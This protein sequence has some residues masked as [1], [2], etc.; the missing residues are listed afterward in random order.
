MK[1]LSTVILLLGT[2][3]CKAQT[4]LQ[5]F[6]L[7]NGGNIKTNGNYTSISVV[8]E[9][10]VSEYSN[11]NYSGT[12]GYLDNTD[13]DPLSI[14]KIVLENMIVD[15]YPNPTKGDTWVKLSLPNTNKVILRVFNNIGISVF[16]EHYSNSKSHMLK[17]QK[18]IFSLSGVYLIE[19][20][21][22]NVKTTRQLTVIK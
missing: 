7:A 6:V 17:L 18:E 14:D 19:I 1:K 4:S 12:I 11:G 13:N 5:K 10:A 8:G 16:E 3:L 15:L 22:N 9:M 2:V 20:S 21:S